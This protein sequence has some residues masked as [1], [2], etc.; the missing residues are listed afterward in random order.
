MLAPTGHPEVHQLNCRAAGPLPAGGALRFEMRIQIPMD[1]PA[2]NNG[3]FWE[4]DPT[5]TR[6]PETTSGVVVADR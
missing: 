5:G 1:A 6:G 4:L 2:G 3:L